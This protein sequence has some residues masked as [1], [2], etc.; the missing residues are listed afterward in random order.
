ME[1]ACPFWP[2]DRQC[3]SKECSIGYCD[4]EFPA[5]LKTPSSMLEAALAAKVAESGDDALE[6][7]KGVKFFGGA[8]KAGLPVPDKP[9]KVNSSST[10]R[11]NQTEPIKIQVDQKKAKR[12]S[13]LSPDDS[14]ETCDKSSQFDPLDRSLTDRQ[15]TSD[16]RR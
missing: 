2:D 10:K 13:H 16:R 12:K 7:I 9:P 4:E 1:K 5:G 6:A 8:K 14:E 11:N 3:S 15:K